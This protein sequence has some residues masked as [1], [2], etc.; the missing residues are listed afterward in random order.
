MEPKKG[1]LENDFTVQLGDFLVPAV[2]FQ[3]CNILEPKKDDGPGRCFCF[4]PR[5]YFQVLR[6][7]GSVDI[8]WIFIFQKDSSKGFRFKHFLERTCSL[9]D[10]NKPTNSNIFPSNH[11]FSAT[12]PTRCST[13]LEKES[14]SKELSLNFGAANHNSSNQT[15][16]TDND[17]ISRPRGIKID[18]TL[19]TAR[20]FFFCG[21][22]LWR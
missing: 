22:I 10:L 6:C 21:E 12:I 20:A 11:V 5:N 14:M 9:A 2:H 18:V 3:G 1:G 16:A 17:L 7:F 13:C 15:C 4:F 8:F 19:G